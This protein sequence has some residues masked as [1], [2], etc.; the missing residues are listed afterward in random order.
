MNKEKYLVS[1]FGKSGSGKSTSAE[2]AERYLESRGVRT[3]KIAVAEP[4]HEMQKFC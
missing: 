1:F 2:I 3:G 4:L